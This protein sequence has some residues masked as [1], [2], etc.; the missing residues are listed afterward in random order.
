MATREHVR[1]RAFLLYPHEQLNLRLL[2]L[3]LGFLVLGD[4]SRTLG[5][6]KPAQQKDPSASLL[7]KLLGDQMNIIS[8]DAYFV[9]LFFFF[10][11]FLHCIILNKA[12]FENVALA[13]IWLITRRNSF[14]N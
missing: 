11:L 7:W 9:I 6:L 2:S 13:E 3:R 14:L 1:K 8:A 10:L 12:V 4:N 5:P